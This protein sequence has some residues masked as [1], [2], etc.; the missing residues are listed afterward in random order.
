MDYFSEL[1][2]S[3]YQLKKR[4]FKL[5]YISEGNA[6]PEAYAQGQEALN[7]PDAVTA[8]KESLKKAGANKEKKAE[9]TPGVT[10]WTNLEGGK[11]ANFNAGGNTKM[12]TIIDGQGVET[13]DWPLYV[14]KFAEPAD[15]EAVGQAG[16]DAE[17]NVPEGELTDVQ[18]K[19]MEIKQQEEEAAAA[20]KAKFERIGGVWEEQHGAP[21][22]EVV[23]E[24]LLKSE[25][26]AQEFCA[27]QAKAGKEESFM[28][29]GNNLMRYIGGASNW[30]LEHKLA[31]GKGVQIEIIP[32][33]DG[34][35][36]EQAV[37]GDLNVALLQE[38][39]ESMALLTDF[40]GNKGGNCEDV[41][42]RVSRYRSGGKN[43]L[44]LYG[45]DTNEDG[46]PEQGI[47]IAPLNPLQDAALKAMEKQCPAGNLR[48][49]TGSQFSQK[50]KNAVKGTFYE[51]TIQAAVAINA[52]DRMPT[53]NSRERWARKTAIKEALAGM[54]AKLEDK[55]GELREVAAEDGEDDIA[56][57]LEAQFDHG[58]IRE[59]MDL[60]ESFVGRCS[61]QGDE[62]AQLSI[63]SG[64][65]DIE[66]DEF[67]CNDAGGTWER[68]DQTLKNWV[69]DEIIAVR[70]AIQV[71]D[72]DDAEATG[73]SEN[74][75]G[76]REDTKF[77]FNQDKDGLTP[78]ERAKKAADLMGGEPVLVR[79]GPHKG[80]WALGA[81]QKRIEKMGKIKIGELNNE[82]RREA[83]YKDED[84]EK[85][86]VEGG[87]MSKIRNMQFGA[88]ETQRQKDA[89][90]YAYGVPDG[91]ETRIKAAT[92]GL[93]KDTAYVDGGGKIK[94]QSATSLLTSIQQKFAGLLSFDQLKRSIV[95]K[96]LMKGGGQ[97]TKRGS[98]D[99]EWRDFNDPTVR[100]RA[101]E[102]VERSARF[103]ILRKD[104]K[105]P[106][107]RQAAQD[108]ILRNALITGANARDM[109]QII[110]DDKG[111]TKTISHNKGL[112]AMCDAQARGKVDFTVKAGG[113]GVVM[114]VNDPGSKFHGMEVKWSQQGTWA[115][116]KNDPDRNTRSQTDYPADTVDTLARDNGIRGEQI[117]NR[118]SSRNDIRAQQAQAAAQPI[119]ASTF[120]KY[121]EGQRN[122]LEVLL[123]QTSNN[124]LL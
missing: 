101:Q 46:D 82:D 28:C 94:N 49:V 18:K 36:R 80:A 66:N 45:G 23:K 70:R 61:I 24:N 51:L 31:Y 97:H 106:A 12:W 75:T 81:G 74:K 29:K 22:D 25:K 104:L 68:D 15:S 123:N 77:I 72:A 115:G 93:E 121:L 85:N 37:V 60:L 105:D 26:S 87:F 109:G 30:G 88:A 65:I 17:G 95:G 40:L 92:E 64:G 71:I 54:A 32:D 53:S 1:L 33:A 119:A 27:R 4:T 108:Y 122:L 78:E 56:R 55:I 90:E 62:A 43:G 8:A 84:L 7:N 48:N 83:I 113:A 117:R 98:R 13:E 19:E 3:Y 20:E 44:I 41:S 91:I 11:T 58:V 2:R 39:T 79:S 96:A 69:L 21:M 114:T 50:A 110:T 112:E 73:Q 120:H 89:E 6:S 47:F 99:A 111:N 57:D 16:T 34:K 67:A 76:G 42:N 14:Q 102:A 59:Q 63:R 118:R 35:E 86:P 52:A 107:K 100:K 10:L 103:A 116:D 5:R 9:V 124:N 38:A